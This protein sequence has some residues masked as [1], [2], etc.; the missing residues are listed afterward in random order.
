MADVQILEELLSRYNFS[1]EVDAK[2]FLDKLLFEGDSSYITE[3]RAAF[4]DN[5][6]IPVSKQFE[7]LYNNI[8]KKLESFDDEKL[9]KV[10]DPFGLSELSKKHESEIKDYENKMLEFLRKDF[11]TNQNI[12]NFSALENTDVG[13]IIEEPTKKIKETENEKNVGEQKGFLPTENVINFSEKTKVFFKDLFYGFG[14]SFSKKIQINTDKK[15]EETGGFGFLKTIGSLLLATG[16]G[17]ILVVAF[18]DKIKPWL[19]SKLGTK[20][21]FLDRFRGIV[22][23]IGKFFTMGGLSLTFGGAF[24]IV[25]GVIKSFGELIESGLS[26]AFK[27]LFSGGAAGEA[28]GDLAKTGT[29]F[30]GMLPRI[31][32]GLFKGIGVTVLKG[33]PLIGSLI[34]FGFAYDRIF[35]K[36][37]FL[38]GTIDLVG[39]IAN[40]L[41]F[42]PLAPLA[43]PLSLGAAALNAF[44]DYKGITGAGSNKRISASIGNFFT[45][46]GKTLMGIPFIANLVNGISGLWNVFSGI[47]SGDYN[48]T[49]NGFELMKGIPFMD[50]V[51]NMWLGLLEMGETGQSSSSKPTFSFGKMMS[52]LKKKI[53]KMILNWFPAGTMRNLAANFLG[54]ESEEKTTEETPKTSEPRKGYE[55][56]EYLKNQQRMVDISKISDDRRKKGESTKLQDEYWEKLNNNRSRM[57]QNWLKKQQM[58]EFKNQQEQFFQDIPEER[59]KSENKFVNDMDFMFENPTASFEDGEIAPNKNTRVRVGNKV[60]K[61]APNDTVSFQKPDGVLDKNLTRLANIMTKL[62]NSIKELNRTPSKEGNNNN[63]FSSVNIAAAGG[64]DSFATSTRDPIFNARLEW[65]KMNPVSRGVI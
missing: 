5:F 21:D 36:G 63:N 18:W 27:A 29:G 32:G 49:K 59:E 60:Y 3:F 1:G 8:K 47:S 17:S 56:D 11:T 31:A 28:A 9:E 55:T 10:T 4:K 46:L 61:A 13:K 58:D 43:L 45:G 41:E 34:S 30:K 6:F 16:V 20:L 19:E 52:E 15:T 2:E 37:D 62:D 64:G 35:N 26:F 40:L 44:L 7:K 42:S 65:W 12:P 14:E 23:G 53:N 38:G 51:S 25:G 24:K 39:G 48:T 50:S 33:I 54:I 22:E 57:F